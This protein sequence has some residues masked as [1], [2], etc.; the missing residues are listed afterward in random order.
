MRVHTVANMPS[1]RT[2]THPLVVRAVA[3]FAAVV[4][5][6]GCWV[7]GT[8]Q[9]TVVT[10][11]IAYVYY[12]KVATDNVVDA[13]HYTVNGGNAR[14]TLSFMLDMAMTQLF[15]NRLAQVG[16]YLSDFDYFFDR[17]NDSD[18]GEAASR[19][20]GN[21]R[22]LVMHRNVNPFGDR[23]NWTYREDSDRYCTYGK[24]YL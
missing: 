11:N 3:L 21:I 5:L 24:G 19:T 10:G 8:P 14:K 9:N 23:H 18:F 6:S 4:L 15:K 16:F 17:A 22:C 12:K 13:L 7:Y 20:R 2:R 1:V